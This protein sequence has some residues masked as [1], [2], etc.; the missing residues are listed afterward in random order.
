MT[1]PRDILKKYGIRPYKGLGQSFLLDNNIT[2][3]IVNVMDIKDDD[4]VVEIGAGLGVM[5]AMIAK[6]ARK[7]IALEI[8]QGLLNV[9]HEELKG[10]SNVEILKQDILKYDFPIPLEDAASQ[11]LKVIGNIPYNISS[12][13]LFRLI[14]FRDHISSMVLMFQ[15]EVAERIMA[16]PGTKE[17]GL[18]SVITSMYTIPSK[19]VVAPAGCFYPKPK[20]DSTVLKM[21][22]REN[23]RF[24]VKNADFFFKLVKT[25]LSKRRKTLL[26][27]LRS[28]NLLRSSKTDIDKILTMLEIDGQRRGETLTVEEFGKLSKAI[29]S[30]MLL[31]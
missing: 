16:S 25:A 14:E 29:L 31:F 5:T 30:K 4:T 26:N 11:K 15:K 17:Y 27:N 6:Q 8:D 2:G 1:S 23:P 22:V 3:K 24:E 10:V 13:I 20:V 18:L 9:L 21:V 12:Q 19:V 28:S 7:V